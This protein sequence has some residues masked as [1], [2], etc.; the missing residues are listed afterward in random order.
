MV[1]SRLRRI[2]RLRRARGHAARRLAG[3]F[4]TPADR[5]AVR[6]PWISYRLRLLLLFLDFFPRAVPSQ[7]ECEEQER[8]EREKREKRVYDNWRRLI[9]GLLIKERLQAKYF[10]HLTEAAEVDGDARGGGGGAASSTKGKRPASV[11]RPSSAR[12]GC[13]AKKRR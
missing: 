9:R 5:L 10:S 11:S 1:A 7:V 6:R 8:R 2:R 13:A 3:S 12:G 4:L